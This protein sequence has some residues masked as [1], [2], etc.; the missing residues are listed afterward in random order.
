MKMFFKPILNK[1][2]KKKY[3]KYF[4]QE[5]HIWWFFQKNT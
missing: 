4:L 3:L 2:L 1:I 5:A